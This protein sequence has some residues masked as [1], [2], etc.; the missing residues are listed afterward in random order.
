[1]TPAQR[2]NLW[3]VT[4]LGYHAWRA[5]SLRLISGHPLTLEREAALFLGLARPAPGET[6]LDAGTST[7][8]YA[9]VLARAGAHVIAT[10]VS[11]AMLAQARR[12]EPSPLID[13]AAFDIQDTGLPDGA[14][15]GVTVGATLNELTDPPG[16]LRELQRLLRPGGR[17]WLMY[18]T[19]TG[20]EVQGLLER[21]GGTTFPDPDDVEG[22]LDGCQPVHTVRYGE[23]C[24][25]L[26]VRK[27]EV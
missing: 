14:L 5:R 19:R 25:Q 6:W 20:G 23:V 4:A 15:D 10:D 22:V 8:F 9:G 3:P 24:L 13:W 11:P 16:G 2:S 26:F 21:L 18:V 7:G 17:L 12:R 1:M 27:Q